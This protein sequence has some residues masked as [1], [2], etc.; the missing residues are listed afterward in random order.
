[1]PGVR[2]APRHT[3]LPNEEAIMD[4]WDATL[5]EAEIAAA[6]GV[7]RA[8]VHSVVGT[9]SETRADRWATHARMASMRLADAIAAL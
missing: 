1:M 5:S 3:M 7:S 9:F 8:S 6:L 4:L 2:L